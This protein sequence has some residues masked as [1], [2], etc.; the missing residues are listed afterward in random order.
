MMI[1]DLSALLK[2]LFAGS[3][4]KSLSVTPS[5]RENK[6]SRLSC[7]FYYCISFFIHTLRD[8][9]FM[10]TYTQSLLM[11]MMMIAHTHIKLQICFS[12]SHKID[13]MYENYFIQQ[14]S[15]GHSLII[16]LLLSFNCILI[17]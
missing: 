9:E 4:R 3:W 7:V 16:N 15:T 6:C 10:Q 17:N 12:L 14:T 5:M 2:R 1:N 11:M 8:D 13:C